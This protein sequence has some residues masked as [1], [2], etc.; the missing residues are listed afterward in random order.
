MARVRPEPAQDRRSIFTEV[1][2]VAEDTM[3][4]V[5]SPAPNAPSFRH[6]RPA[7]TVRFRSRNDVFGETANDDE[8]D[9]ESVADEDEARPSVVEVP[10]SYANQNTMS[11]KFLRLG[12]FAFV[13]A[14]ML[15]LVSMNG[16][17]P[18]GVQ[19]NTIPRSTVDANPDAMVVKRADSPT[20][21]CKRWS[22]QS[23]VVNGT[24][25]MYGFRRS[26]E[27]NQADG[28]WSTFDQG[29]PR[30]RR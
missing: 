4:D 19:G 18:L 20:D 14:I 3:K 11:T 15:P 16:L 24:L 5:R 23:T 30:C 2:L 21:A 1:G 26:T 7:R 9:W 28:T 25:Y 17:T 12:I 6:L 29:E 13:L 10:A 8:S 22:G 27:P